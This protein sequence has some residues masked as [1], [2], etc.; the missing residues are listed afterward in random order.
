M[1]V[2]LMI[3]NPINDREK[4]FNLPIST[5]GVFQDH[6]MPIITE[7][8][9][10]WIRCFQSGIELDKE[11]IELVLAELEKMHNWIVTYKDNER[12]EQMLER[13][14]S[15]NETLIEILNTSRKDIKVYIG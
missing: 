10:E 3:S 15:L 11:D 5:E 8:D 13:L 14:K 2:S 1:S 9:L 6:W 7:L 4:Y 12:G